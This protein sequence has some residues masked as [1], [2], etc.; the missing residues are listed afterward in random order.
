MFFS[1]QQKAKLWTEQ[2]EIQKYASSKNGTIGRDEVYRR[3]RAELMGQV[4]NRGER[5][6]LWYHIVRIASSLLMA[7]ESQQRVRIRLGLI[8]VT[9]HIQTY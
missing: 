4:L 8:D 5:N 1:Q 3:S 6:A 7:F 9:Q 2:T